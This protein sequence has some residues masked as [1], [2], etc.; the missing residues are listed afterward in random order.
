[1]NILILILVGLGGVWLGRRLA[2]IK[3][4]Q[5][6]LEAMGPEYS[7]GSAGHLA[8][9][10]EERRELKEEAKEKI[11]DFIRQNGRAKNDD[12]EKLLGVSDATTTNYLSEL[13]QEGKISQSGGEEGRGVFYTLK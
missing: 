1:M 3:L 12:I 9:V 6:H 11:M 2:I 8:G 5:K 13:E 4:K 10:N 7:R